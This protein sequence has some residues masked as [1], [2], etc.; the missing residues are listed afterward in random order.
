MNAKIEN[1]LKQ[2]SFLL[3][4]MIEKEVIFNI[5]Q[6]RFLSVFQNIYMQ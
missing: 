4:S 3:T 5:R 6:Q 2:I 1:E